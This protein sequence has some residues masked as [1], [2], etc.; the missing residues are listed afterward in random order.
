MALRVLQLQNGLAIEKI[1]PRKNLIE[2]DEIVANT[3]TLVS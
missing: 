1:M 2:M 3:F